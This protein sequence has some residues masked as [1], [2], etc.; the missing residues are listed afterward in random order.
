[1]GMKPTRWQQR[2]ENFTKAFLLLEST[3]Q[4]KELTQFSDLEKEGIVQRFEYTF[5]LAWK[6]LKD[7]LEASGVVLPQITPK[8]VLK[9]AFSAKIIANATSWSQMLESRNMAS[10]TYDKKKCEALVELIAISFLP[11]LKEMF[12]TFQKLD[13]SV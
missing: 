3:F 5:E 9:E 11:E 8:Q 1:M 6:T 10:H 12:A 13:T 2:F 4:G 7:Y